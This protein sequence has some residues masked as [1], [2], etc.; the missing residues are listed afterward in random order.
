MRRIGLLAALALAAGPLAAQPAKLAP[1][2]SPGVHSAPPPPPAEPQTA[3]D[4][5]PA[6]A[7]ALPPT[8][9]R[10]VQADPAYRYDQPVAERRSWTDRLKEAVARF[11]ARA[12]EAVGPTGVQWIAYTLAAVAV[13]WA[14]SRLLGA[15]TG[16][17]FGRRD[18]RRQTAGP[19]LDVEDI[20]EVDLAALLAAARAEGDWRAA[21]RLRYLV[22][23]QALA[24]AGAIA[25]ARDKTNRTYAAEL[26]AWD[27]AH[28]GDGAAL[29]PPFAEA[30]RLF[31]RVW[32]GGLDGSAARFDRLD[33]AARD[34]ER[35]P[36]P[37]PA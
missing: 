21:V 27:A 33:A 23:L 22:L 16:G 4:A 13:G 3:A 18:R 5:E 7:R 20:A 15:D 31:E 26:R 36:S 17:L 10:A 37:V 6:R 30:T 29:A 19:L 12:F 14:L 35:V 34:A 1:S 2:A 32:Y 8:E 28:S 25:W 24:A 11:L 9:L